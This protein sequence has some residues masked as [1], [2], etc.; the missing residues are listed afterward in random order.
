[1]P[2]ES[3]EHHRVYMNGFCAHR[4]GINL[5]IGLGW[6]VPNFGTKDYDTLNEYDVALANH[7][8]P[9]REGVYLVVLRVRLTAILA[10]GQVGLGLDGA[11]FGVDYGLIV[12]DIP[13][14]TAGEQG[15]E[16][17]LLRHLNRGDFMQPIILN[18]TGNPLTMSGG[19]NDSQFSAQRLTRDE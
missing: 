11:G 10:A 6:T 12:T 7:F 16:L 2:N 1:M 13:V 9:A 19:I 17:V 15:L 18:G 14:G 8:F 4:N 3:T 5:A